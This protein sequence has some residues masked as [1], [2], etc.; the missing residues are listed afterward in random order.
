[1]AAGGLSL[2]AFGWINFGL[3]TYLPYVDPS[4]MGRDVTYRGEDL[5][6]TWAWLVLWMSLSMLVSAGLPR[7]RGPGAGGVGLSPRWWTLRGSPPGAMLQGVGGLIVAGG[8]L[9]G[10]VIGNMFLFS[11]PGD[12]CTYPSC[13]PYREQTVVLVAPGVLAGV[14][15]VAAACLVGHVRWW[16]RAFAPVLVWVVTL[17]VQHLIWTPY[18]LPLFE[19]PPR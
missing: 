6:A 13:W 8:T 2:V 1:M 18:L 15:M 17:I 12:G 5:D 9:L 16:V 11:G 4:E 19:G 7:Q 14:S 10:Y 3:S